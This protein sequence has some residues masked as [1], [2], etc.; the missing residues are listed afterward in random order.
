MKWCAQT[1]PPIFGLF[2]IFDRNLL[3]IMAPSSNKSKNYLV[4]LKGRCKQSQNRPINRDTLHVRTVH[5]S[6]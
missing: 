1:F 5:P 2:A 6:N 4:H 3:K